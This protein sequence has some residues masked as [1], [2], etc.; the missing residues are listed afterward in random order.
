MH[1]GSRAQ[2]CLECP[3]KI[4]DLS[5]QEVCDLIGRISDIS[6]EHASQYQARVL[7]HNINGLVLSVCQL[8]QLRRELDMTFGD[9]QLFSTLVSHLRRTEAISCGDKG[10]DMLGDSGICLVPGQLSFSTLDQYTSQDKVMHESGNQNS[11]LPTP[12]EISRPV[13]SILHTDALGDP[14]LQARYHCQSAGPELKTPGDGW[15]TSPM[16]TVNS[17]SGMSTGVEGDSGRP[18][19]TALLHQ[20][21]PPSARKAA[22]PTS[23]Q[24]TGMDATPMGAGSPSLEE[25]ESLWRRMARPEPLAEAKTYQQTEESEP[26]GGE[27]KQTSQPPSL[28]SAHRSESRRQKSSTDRHVARGSGTGRT[29]RCYTSLSTTDLRSVTALAAAAYYN[30]L[31]A[32]TPHHYKAPPTRLPCLAGFLAPSAYI[33][34]PL[35]R[36]SRQQAYPTT[37]HHRAQTRQQQH[38]MRHH[39][40][41]GNEKRRAGSTKTKLAGSSPHRADH[42]ATPGGR[43][44][45][46]G[47]STASDAT[48]WRSFSQ[49][50]EKMLSTRLRPHASARS[51]ILAAAAAAAACHPCHHSLHPAPNFYPLLYA[52]PQ[53][54]PPPPPPPPEGPA[55][56]GQ[57]LPFTS[58]LTTS[59]SQGL[60]DLEPVEREQNSLND[61]SL[62]SEDGQ[63]QNSPRNKQGG[64]VKKAV[65]RTRKRGK[66]EEFN[67]KSSSGSTVLEHRQAMRGKKD[68]NESIRRHANEEDEDAEEV[69]EEETDE[70]YEN[71]M[72]VENASNEHSGNE[73]GRSQ[74]EEEDEDDEQEEGEE[75]EDEDLGLLGEDEN[76]EERSE[77]SEQVDMRDEEDEE[78]EQDEGEEIVDEESENND[79]D[80]E[81]DD[82]EDE[83]EEEEDIDHMN[84]EFTPGTETDENNRFPVRQKQMQLQ[85]ANIPNSNEVGCF[86]SALRRSNS[87]VLNGDASQM[88]GLAVNMTDLKLSPGRIAKC[89]FEAS[90]ETNQMMPS[91]SLGRPGSLKSASEISQEPHSGLTSLGLPNTG[92][93]EGASLI[94]A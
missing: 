89:S 70:L 90:V 79:E 36:F 1:Q 86:Y 6:A 44:T 42:P 80:D 47:R 66:M 48:L 52:P 50:Q 85:E 2:T 51:A 61:G 71:E 43:T 55:S 41:S 45:R 78:Q 58:W 63:V 67:R 69:V 88:A 75:A 19:D 8:D 31:M 83:E 10:I 22:S 25:P 57:H 68:E 30:Q 46:A 16:M 37:P 38:Q 15:L 81:I 23:P 65:R 59:R 54:A 24:E 4:S 14:A 32:S 40:V 13:A 12:G 5:V 62:T 9:W 56:P 20:I 35:G 33:G 11:N 17:S 92:Q 26:T 64:T 73:T 28:Q 53:L 3:P 93:T 84:D 27:A 94:D 34:Q 82:D 77:I 91:R 18:T 60:G 72:P 87:P 7:E 21:T 49:S 39:S 29:G 76:E 74:D